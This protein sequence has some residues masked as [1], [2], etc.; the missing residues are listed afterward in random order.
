MGIDKEVEVK[1]LLTEK[2]VIS[3]HIYLQR[4]ST[5]FKAI[6]ISI[7]IILFYREL[8]EMPLLATIALSIFYYLFLY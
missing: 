5:T 8:Y 2:E 7:M 3:S 6:C 4:K 1:V